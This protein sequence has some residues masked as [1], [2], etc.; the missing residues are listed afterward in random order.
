M[1]V[2]VCFVCHNVVN[3]G[4]MKGVGGG[5]MFSIVG[6]RGNASRGRGTENA[7]AESTSSGIYHKRSLHGLN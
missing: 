1:C 3:Q 5:V 2:G 7:R 4:R 6:T